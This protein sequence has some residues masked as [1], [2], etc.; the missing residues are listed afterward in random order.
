MKLRELTDPPDAALAAALQAFEQ[1]F[2]YPL[3]RGWFRIAHGEDYIR[4]YRSMG[5]AS[6]VVAEDENGIV[7][8]CCAAQ[9]ELCQPRRPAQGALYLGD[10]KLAPRA[11]GGRV[12]WRLAQVL[13]ACHPEIEGA[14]SVVMDGT[15]QN[16]AS[17]TGRAGLPAFHAVGAVKIW[18]LPTAP[19]DEQT[20]D[21]VAAAT[22]EGE[23]MFRA[24]ASEQCFSLS[25]DPEQRSLLPVQ[26]WLTSDRQACGRLEDTRLAKRLFRDDG[27]EIVSAHLS[28]FAYA[29]PQSGDRLLRAM[30]H[31]VAQA[32]VPALFVAQ[33]DSA[34]PLPAMLEQPPE[35]TIVSRATIYAAMLAGDSPWNVFT[36]EI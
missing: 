28:A 27:E 36:A 32:G 29:T 6:Y 18:R 5:R 26:W 9:R 11:R 22:P 13:R 1:Q 25:G 19:H 24:L 10:L 2:R 8:V 3:D 16:P 15:S 14:Y 31:R 23:S 34:A 35:G 7:G 4:F 21:V 33:P 20:G 12:L 30:C 17:Y